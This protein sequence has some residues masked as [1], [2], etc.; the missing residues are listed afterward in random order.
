MNKAEISK[1]VEQGL[2]N[3]DQASQIKQL[4]PRFYA[5]WAG[6]VLGM[7]AI[8]QIIVAICLVI[9]S[10]WDQMGDIIPQLGVA[11]LL[12]L[13]LLGC[14]M[15]YRRKAP[16]LA[17]GCA[18]ATLAFLNANLV[19]QDDLRELDLHVLDYMSLVWL[20]SLLLVLFLP[21]RVLSY[22]F[23]ICSVA[24]L[25]GLTSLECHWMGLSETLP[26]GMGNFIILATIMLFASIGDMASQ[27]RS[28]YQSWQGFATL[29]WYC[30]PLVSIGLI[31]YID[32]EDYTLSNYLITIA[33]IPLL[34]IGLCVREGW[35][36]SITRLL[37]CLSPLACVLLSLICLPED[38]VVIVIALCAMSLLYYWHSLRN[39]GRPIWI[40]VSILILM[41]SNGFLIINFNGNEAFAN[42]WLYRCMILVAEALIILLLGRIY[43]QARHRAPIPTPQPQPEAQPQGVPSLP[44]VPPINPQS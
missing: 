34:Y 33:P 20:A 24:F 40:A 37:I 15:F 5:L 27:L 29:A 19:L 43:L 11:A 30:I 12:L 26:D 28:R 2:L 25:K 31:L 32:T 13:S 22:A 3:P 4:G 17:N 39:N 8:L 21:L 1:L 23:F 14:I 44:P 36:F 10:Y 35:G 7:V 9:S 6:R 18:I 38:W 42:G 41:I 16:L